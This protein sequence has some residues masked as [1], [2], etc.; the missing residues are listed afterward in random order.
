MVAV[1]SHSDRDFGNGS[2]QIV[3]GRRMPPDTV[4]TFVSASVGFLNGL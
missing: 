1:V 4:G 2:K 3:E